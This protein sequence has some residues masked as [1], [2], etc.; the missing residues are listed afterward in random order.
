MSITY[1][2]GAK[3]LPMPAALRAAVQ[4]GHVHR[5]F[6]PDGQ[7]GYVVPLN[8][9]ERAEVLQAIERRSAWE[10]HLATMEGAVV[11]IAVVL[12]GYWLFNSAMPS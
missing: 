11:G 6:G 9:P 12:L 1:R 4:Q 2:L 3:L 10:R 7:A 5:V 8:C